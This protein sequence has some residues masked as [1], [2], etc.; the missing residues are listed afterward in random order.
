MTTKTESVLSAAQTIVHG[1]RAATYGHPTDH[2]SK[3][4]KMWSTILDTDVLPEHVWLCLIALK[5]AR[6]AHNP[7]RDNRVDIAGY[8]ET[9][10]MLHVNRVQRA[11]AVKRH[12]L[13]LE[14]DALRLVRGRTPSGGEDV[15]VEQTEA[16]RHHPV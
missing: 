10:E 16:V 13:R 11:E 4:A 3:V 5:L 14:E 9:L 7:K 1:E 2:F 15:V 12:V 6:E 8:A